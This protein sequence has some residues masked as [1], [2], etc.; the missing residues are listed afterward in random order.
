MRYKI[1]LIENLVMGVMCLQTLV[2][3]IIIWRMVFV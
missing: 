1:E 3:N 2:V